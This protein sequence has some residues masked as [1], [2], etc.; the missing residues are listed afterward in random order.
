[1]ERVYVSTGIRL[2]VSE[3][4]PS[5]D[6]FLGGKKWEKWLENFEDELTL[7][8]VETE[9]Q[10]LVCL[11]RY[12]GDLIKQLIRDLPASEADEVGDSEFTKSK[13]KLNEYF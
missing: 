4:E 10:K 9:E 2:Y 6:R 13:R 12:G 11:K 3:F 8:N 7:Q 1:M 5:E